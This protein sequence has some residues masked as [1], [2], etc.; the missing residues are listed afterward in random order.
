MKDGHRTKRSRQQV[1]KPKEI[2]APFFDP[3][4]GPEE[5]AAMTKLATKLSR[6]LHHRA[7]RSV[8]KSDGEHKVAQADAKSV[9]KAKKEQAA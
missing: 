4:S 3:K 7:T 9:H 8:N 2:L 1:S 6:H 5:T